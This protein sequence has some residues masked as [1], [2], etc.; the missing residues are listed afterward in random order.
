MKV[1]IS[2]LMFFAFFAIFSSMA[3]AQTVFFSEDFSGGLEKWEDVR[4][5]SHLW[6]IEDGKMKVNITSRGRIIELIPKD[7]YW[8]DDWKNYSYKIEIEAIAGA[9]KNISFGYEDVGNWY[10]IHFN[11]HSGMYEVVRLENKRVVFSK[12]GR[13][14]LANG[15]NHEVEIIKDQD[16]IEIIVNGQTI[17]NLSDPSFAEN[18]G[19]IGVKAGTGSIYPTTVNFDNIVV[20]SLE[21][22]PDNQ[23]DIALQKQSDAEW[24][25]EEYDHATEWSSKPT[26]G[27]WGCALS[28]LSMILNFHNASTLP[29][30]EAMTPKTLNDWLKSQADGYLGKGLLNWVAATRL[31]RLMNEQYG[32]KKLEYAFVGGSSIDTAKFEINAEKP[33]VLQID[34]HFLVGSGVTE[35]GNDLY[36]KDPAYSYSQFS[37][38]NK[39]LLST[40]KLTPSNTDL[41]YFLFSTD[42]GVELKLLDEA[43]SQLSLESVLEKVSDPLDGSGEE[44]QLRLWQ[45]AKPSTGNYYLEFSSQDASAEAELYLY[46][47]DANVTSFEPMLHFYD[48]PLRFELQYD[49]EGASS[50]RQIVDFEQFKKDLK[51]VRDSRDLR[52][53]SVYGK[54]LRLVYL[55]ERYEDSRRARYFMLIER[56]LQRY[57][58]YFSDD[59]YGYIMQQ[60]NALRENY[61]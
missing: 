36:I 35:D 11:S 55:A 2:I 47:Q 45:L 30:G 1:Y 23:L 61:S 12:F 7:E 49:K 39:E 5:G 33:P 17:E 56:Y 34:G 6:K 3:S 14:T 37:E 46:D 28:S 26:I 27:R 40:R 18:T 52:S 8:N 32:S 4:G 13:F 25:D 10:E 51:S 29:N 48:A 43:Y 50:L 16:R 41:S 59:S 57:E 9:D 44:T 53:R 15:S 19:K 38:H 60:Y 20:T 24:K 42:D 54:I 21:E 31:T 22:T 58:R